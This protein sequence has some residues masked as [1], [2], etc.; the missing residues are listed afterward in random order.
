MTHKARNVEEDEKM[1]ESV[2]DAPRPSL[3]PA[4]WTASEDGT[5]VLSP[6]AQEKVQKT[7]DYVQAKN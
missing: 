4:V 1:K 7:V 5:F 6:E 3:D 2:L